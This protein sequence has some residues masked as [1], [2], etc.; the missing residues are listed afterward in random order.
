MKS[1]H[2]TKVLLCA[3]LGFASA[4]HVNAQGGAAARLAVELTEQ[5]AKRG[6]STAARE[7]AEFGGEAAVREVLQAAEKEGGQQLVEI[8]SR[9]A[10]KHGLVALQAMKGAPKLV[11]EAVEKLPQ[12][13]AENGLRAVVREPLVMQKIITETGEAGLEAAA[14]FPGVGSQVASKLGKEGVETLTSSAVKESGEK[15]AIALAKHADD[16]AKLA[17]VERGGLLAMMK[18]AP[19]KVVKFLGRHPV[20]TLT[21]AV[22]ASFLLNPDAYLGSADAPGIIER[23]VGAPVRTAGYALAALVAIWGGLKLLFAWR[24]MR[25]KLAK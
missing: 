22:V 4:S 14:R 12:E 21:A 10:G 24:G 15:A 6:G 11:A 18:S 23:M 5:I 3:A 8:V 19:E 9:Q 20:G 16:I 2:F 7:L 13:L 1:Q 25:R 17:P